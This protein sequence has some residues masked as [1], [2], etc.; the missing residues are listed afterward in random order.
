M[1]VSRL[2]PVSVSHFTC[3]NANSVAL[4]SCFLPGFPT[5]CC[6]HYHVSPRTLLVQGALRLF[7]KPLLIEQSS[8]AP[9]LK[10]EMCCYR[11]PLFVQSSSLC[12]GA[13]LP[14][15]S[16]VAIAIAGVITTLNSTWYLRGEPSSDGC[17]WLWLVVSGS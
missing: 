11:C 14:F 3:L 12:A 16:A 6:T 9:V 2:S 13:L 10:L 4:F 8:K 15:N 5:Y 7:V 17:I 1:P